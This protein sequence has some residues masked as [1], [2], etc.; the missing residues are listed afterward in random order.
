MLETI[1][2]KSSSMPMALDVL[3]YVYT[4]MHN[5]NKSTGK[6]K[7]S[8]CAD[9]ESCL[10]GMSVGDRKVQYTFFCYKQGEDR[11]Y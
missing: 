3:S 2:K 10:Q 1:Y 8:R 4:G 5:R 9:I 7:T 11:V 6:G